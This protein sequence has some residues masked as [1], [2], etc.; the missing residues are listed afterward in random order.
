[1]SRDLG[2]VEVLEET[3]VSIPV[4]L[5]YEKVY[6]I[7]VGSRPFKLSGASLLSDAPS[8]FSNFFCQMENANKTLFVDRSPAVFEKIYLHLQGYHVAADNDLDYTHLWVDAFYFGLKKL[9]R[10]LRNEPLFA[11]VG[12]RLF[13]IPR[14][15]FRAENCPNFFLINSDNLIMESLPPGIPL[16]MI[17]PPPQRPHLTVNRSPSLF[18][19]LMEIMW[20]NMGVI[21]DD[22]HRQLLVKE[23][24]YY[25]FLELEQRILPHKIV[26]N[27]FTHSEE[28]IMKLE[29]L[30]RS[31]V[32]NSSSTYQEEALTT[33]VRPY[34]VGEPKRTLLVQIDAESHSELRLIMSRK[35]E[36][37]LLVMTHKLANTMA[38]AFPDIAVHYADDLKTGKLTILCG[39]LKSSVTI[40]GIP[41]RHDWYLDFLTRTNAEPEPKMQKTHPEGDYV[42]FKVTKSLWR[43]IQ[44]QHRIRLHAVSID[45]VSDNYYFHQTLKFL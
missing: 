6:V 42:E 38:T 35:T 30:H 8:Y 45:A 7:Q 37:A 17:R 31:G 24:K 3:D 32:E 34:I 26:Y 1:M 27:P 22:Q 33:Y 21:R 11:T 41:L 28:I 9:Q 36:V 29:D 14:H 20:G 40:N 16:P 43:I 5:P 25:R 23:C 13:K 19:D 10:L 2:S 39:L 44:R 15:L 4:I 12:D 18:A